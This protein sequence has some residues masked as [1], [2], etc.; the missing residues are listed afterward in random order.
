M[1]FRNTFHRVLRIAN[2]TAE[3]IS[4]WLHG[5]FGGKKAAKPYRT[6]VVQGDLPKE[7]KSRTLYVVV[8][9]G[10]NEQAAMLCPCGCG[11]ILHLNLNPDDR[12][13]WKV[14]QHTDG[15]STL[16]PSVNRMKGCKSHF[17]FRQ[18]HV[19]WCQ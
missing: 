17:W 18:G 16:H 8:D 3:A 10:F 14:T 11:N 12:P 5:L 1:I 4:R 2:R 7:L 6:L 13:C 15:T 19:D 9:D